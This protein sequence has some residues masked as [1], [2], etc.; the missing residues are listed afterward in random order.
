MRGRVEL[1]ARLT[2]FLCAGAVVVSTALSASPAALARN[3]GTTISAS[4]TAAGHLT[5]TYQW[6]VQKSAS[7]D[8]QMVPVG[9]S[10][11]VSYAIATTK[12]SSGAIDAWLDG[13]VCVTNTGSAD[14]QGLAIS[15]QLTQPPSKS[16]L[17]SVPVDVSALPVLAAGASWCYPFR[18]SVPAA[19]I[20]AGATYKDSAKVTITNHSGHLGVPTGP[21]PRTTAVLPGSPA[22]VDGS[23]TVNDSNGQTF[24]FA[25]EGTASYR[26]SFACASAAGAQ[27]MIEN[28]TA[29]IAS[30]GQ[31]ASAAATIHCGAPT[32]VAT[33]LS[34]GTIGQG[35]SASDQAT[36]S[37]AA[38]TAGG[39]I[40]YYVY[41]DAT[42]TTQIADA[43]PAEN[44]VVNGVAPASASIT[45]NTTGS[46]WWVAV[47]SGDPSANTLGSKSDCAAE[48]LTVQPND[49]SISADPS[50]LSLSQQDAAISSISTAVVSGSAGTIDLSVSG[51]P[52]GA[53]ATLNPTSV[54][55]GNSSMLDIATGTA[56]PG[57]YTLTVTGT[58]GTTTHT[59][60]L[61]LTVKALNDFSI[62]ASPSSVNVSQGASGNSTI[63]TTVV[64]GSAGTVDLTVTG[65]P[66][67]A[68]ANLNPASVT[69]GGSSTVTIDT[70]TAAAGTYTLT[71]TGVEG[72]VMHSTQLT[73]TVTQPRTNDFSL[74]ASPNRITVQQG[75]PASSTIITAV[76]NGS[77]ETVALTASGLPSG[78]SASF[79]PTSLPAGG[80]STLTIDTGTAAAGSYTLTV[81]GTA[82]SATHSATIAL[83]ITSSSQS[84]GITNGGFE[85]G[86]LSGWSSS[87]ASETVVSSG[88]HSGSH[89]AMLGST[90]P[91]NGDS[92]ISQTFTAPSGT[93]GLS[94]Y[95]KVICPDTVTYDWALATLTD[96]TA[97]TTATV[98]SKTCSNSGAWVQATGSVTAGH[99]YTLTLTSH[100]DNYA[101]DPTYTLFDDV[102][103]T[104]APPPPAGITNGGFETGSFSGWSSSG[105]SETVVSSGCH[106]G[107]YCA[108]LGS[109][110]PTN[111]DS[112]ISQ[113]FT[114]PS[115]KSQLSLW[116]EET[117]PDTVTYD[118]ALVTLTDN[119]AGGTTTTVL[120]KTCSTT[121]WTN[122]TASV[123]AGHIYTLTLTNHDDNYA[124]DPTYTLFDDV[125]LN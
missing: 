27:T 37:G 39:T 33:T 81:T 36:I 120:T 74:S 9:S 19:S 20:V 71:I 44:T 107:T 112:S 40:K 99:S 123:T 92:S 61:T 43:T 121:A 23:I 11:T 116:Y 119:S 77:A 1:I 6:T 87:G 55:A 75:N 13:T 45:F 3:S 25:S 73:M 15:D 52:S 22:V 53:S 26:Q 93:T 103:L 14:T 4:V 98:L 89:C 28:N 83:T 69:A 101:A 82:A 124:A 5:S 91:T 114:V 16:V 57:T 60:Q 88:C 115:G 80:S 24:N 66:S 104:S 21:T 7:P 96:N 56:A 29:T 51:L 78:A 59:T 10:A 35:T 113:Q 90:S 64:S 2:G 95:Y 18:I 63:S 30:T 68:S 41:S 12:S 31:S 58:E 67:G 117:C 85:T 50:S 34:K 102:T 79:S 111:G 125:A 49:F 70:G 106:G 108:M 62:S 105:A 47:Y 42:C 17:S 100:D 72:S 54:T 8:T 32:T 48:P 97:G 84:S 46:Y 65:A 109:T 122:V 86:D 94:L 38:A 110:R 76:T 118:W